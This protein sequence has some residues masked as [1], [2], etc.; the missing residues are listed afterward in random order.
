MKLS[1]SLTEEDVAFVD[2][3]AAQA[4]VRSRSAVIHQ[5]IDLL[6]SADLEKAYA[7][8]WDEW[9]DSEDAQ[10][11]DATTSDGLVDAPR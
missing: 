6:R 8:A 2:E 11:W 7:A 10:L 4:G 5:A 3:Y 9:D 1:V